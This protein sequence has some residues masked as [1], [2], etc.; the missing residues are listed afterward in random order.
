[1]NSKIQ[2]NGQ[3]LYPVSVHYLKSV[4][5]ELG[6]ILSDTFREGSS[7]ITASIRDSMMQAIEES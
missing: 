3:L 2:R 7:F 5:E 1:M 4:G 6:D